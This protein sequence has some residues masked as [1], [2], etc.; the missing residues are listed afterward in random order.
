[1]ECVICNEI[2]KKK[3]N[4]GLECAHMFHTRC[5]IKLVRKRYRKCPLCRLQIR[6]NVKQLFRHEKLYK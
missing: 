2:I 4:V 5:I 6:W 1:M 3:D